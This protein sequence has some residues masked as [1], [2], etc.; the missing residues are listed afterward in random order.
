VH[1]LRAWPRRPRVALFVALITLVA[2][3][4]VVPLA[5]AAPPPNPT[6]TQLKSAAA[7]KAA[8]NQ[9]VGALAAQVA[10]AQ[11]QLQVLEAQAEGAQQRADYELQLLQQAQLAATAARAA[12]GA[13]QQKVNQAQEN[14]VAYAQA[15]YMNGSVAGATGTL[16]TAQNPS[17]LL[18][19]STIQDYQ[20]THQLNAIGAMQRATVGKS[21]A[22]AAARSA[23]AKQQQAAAAATSA[24]Q[25]AVQAAASAV[26][27]EK[28]LQTT[29]S[30][31][32][33]QLQTAQLALATLYNQR[34]TFLAYQKEQARLAAIAAAKKLAQEKAAAAQALAAARLREQQQQQQQQQ[35][36]SGGAVS[37]GS[38]S[39]SSAPVPTGGSWTAA[40]GQAAANRALAYLGIIYA[41]DGG[42][43]NGPTRGVCAGN[44]AFNDCNVIGFDCSGLSLYAWAPYI[45]LYHYTVTQ[46]NQAGSYHPSPGNFMPGDLLFW[47]SDGTI[48][49][50]HHVAIYIGGGNVIQAP[51]SGEV[52][53]ITPWDQVD[54]GYYGATRPLT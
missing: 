5:T 7:Q 37:G 38:D 52:V 13:A 27:Q 24:K 44:G 50:I 42:N 1:V 21:N 34:A 35:Q 48:N 3:L 2:G 16:L 33:A 43:A 8:L 40:A 31:S 25:Q 51:Q 6:D 17:E 54:W 41:W 28:S 15:A 47:S 30:A 39:G 49:G 36:S 46:Y 20:A 11:N 45:S 18:Q 9:Q 26:I 12:V 22:D 10:H 19:Q 29:L 14:F 4:V 53:Q 32:Q 23:V